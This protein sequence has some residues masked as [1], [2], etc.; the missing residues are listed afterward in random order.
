MGNCEI[1]WS[2]LSQDII[3]MMIPPQLKNMV[4]S[5]QA[6]KN[7]WKA[8]VEGT[9]YGHMCMPFYLARILVPV[10][11]KYSLLCTNQLDFFFCGNG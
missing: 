3:I 10:Q 1:L 11:N 7:V 9:L 5:Q 2:L 6:K 8:Q 4:A